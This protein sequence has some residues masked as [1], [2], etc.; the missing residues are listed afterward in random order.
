M[1]FY[2][3]SG[4]AAVPELIDVLTPTPTPRPTPTPMPMVN[5]PSIKLNNEYGPMAVTSYYSS[6]KVM[7]Y[8][9]VSS[10]VFTKIEAT[11]RDK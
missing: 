3:N 2:S 1:E 6:G 7:Y 10:L 5:V 11:S 4:H 8:N 9:S